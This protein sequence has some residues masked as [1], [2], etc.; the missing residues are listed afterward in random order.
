LLVFALVTA[1]HLRVRSETGASTSLL[2]LAI[3]T[4]TIVLLTFIFNTLV[5]E[6]ATAV[7]IVA[8]LLLSVMLDFAWKRARDGARSA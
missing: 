3:G 4:T 5:D 2:L 8:I 1:G 6:P 7:T